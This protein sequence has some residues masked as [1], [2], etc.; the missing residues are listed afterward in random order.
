MTDR[1]RRDEKPERIDAACL[2]CLRCAGRHAPSGGCP[3]EGTTCAVGRCPNREDFVR[4]VESLTA[5]RDALN[6]QQERTLFTVNQ[7]AATLLRIEAERDRL[8][9]K[10]TAVEA[11]L[12]EHSIEI[13]Y[14]ASDGD[15]CDLFIAVDDV[16]AALSSGE[17]QTG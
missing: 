2:R 14:E 1:E 12:V 11:A 6:A 7:V 5:D 8:A 15:G 13:G 16:R 10:I 9:E 4:W 3:P 17:D